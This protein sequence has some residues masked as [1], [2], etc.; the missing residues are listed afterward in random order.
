MTHLKFD[1]NLPSCYNIS[2]M[3][4]LKFSAYLEWIRGNHSFKDRKVRLESS[5]IGQFKVNLYDFQNF[6]FL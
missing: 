5:K 4:I 3:I 2:D 1:K 6:I